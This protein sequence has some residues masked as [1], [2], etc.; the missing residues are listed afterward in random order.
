MQGYTNVKLKGL[1][2]TINTKIP[3]VTLEGIKLYS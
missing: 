2:I 3:L 1:L